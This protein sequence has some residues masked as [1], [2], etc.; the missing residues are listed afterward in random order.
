M[1]LSRL[2]FE[3]WI[4][5][6]CYNNAYILF[7]KRKWRRWSNILIA[8]SA[9]YILLRWAIFSLYEVLVGKNIVAR[10]MRNDNRRQFRHEIA[11]VSIS[12]NEAPYIKEWIEF[13]KCVGFTKFYFYDNESEDNT[14]EV[15]KPYISSGIV[16]YTFI[17]GKGKQL[18]AYN[19]AIEKHKDE[20]RWMAFLDMD[21]YLMPTE[22]FKSISKI[23]TELIGMAGKGAAGVGVNWCIYGS[24]HLEK[25]PEGL[26]SENFINRGTE[27]DWG[28]FHI[29]TICNPRLVKNYISPHYPIYR[30]GGYSINDSDGKRLWGWF[31]HDVKWQNLRINHY[32][33]KSK[34]QYIQKVS[35]GFGDRTGEYD[36]KQFNDYDLNE[37]KDEVMNIY[38][39]KIKTTVYENSFLAKLP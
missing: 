26:I 5:C 7:I 6:Y 19:D 16:E 11:M 29:K 28:N 32:Y 30:L 35:R 27:K 15:L 12:K 34:E 25:K 36:M 13:H 21:E 31:C 2:K 22:P 8:L 23:V 18:Y 17:K 9:P 33:C 4:R 3:A 37:I 14:Y 1:K 38:I 24:S 10:I 39:E 20:C